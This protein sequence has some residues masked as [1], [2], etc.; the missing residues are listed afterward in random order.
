MDIKI[1]AYHTSYSKYAFDFS[2]ALL[3]L[4][5][6]LPLIFIISLL[7]TLINSGPAI[8]KQKRVGKAGKLF[9]LYKFRT[10]RVGAERERG[11]LLKFNEADGPVFKIYDDPR[12]TKFGKILAR[13]GL[14]ELPQLINVL[15]GEMSLVGPRPLPTYEAEKLNPSQ[16]V[17]E[18][19]KPGITSSWIVRGAHQLKFREWM[20][21]DKKYVEEASL[22]KDILILS[23]TLLTIVRLL[24]KLL[25]PKN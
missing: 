12:L 13:S 8:F 18:L 15:K 20:A 14:D 19:V 23:E 24:F 11:K 21:L 7:L 1:S 5:L 9:I 10:M 22:K 17:R 3:L 25:S 6:S 16:R 4:I 2:L